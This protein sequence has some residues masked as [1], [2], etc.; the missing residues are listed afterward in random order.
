MKRRKTISR[1][2]LDELKEE[3]SCHR[4]NEWAELFH[5]LLVVAIICLV[6]VALWFPNILSQSFPEFAV[7]LGPVK[8]LVAGFVEIFVLVLELIDSSEKTR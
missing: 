1:M 8:A 7:I 4:N 2:N 6:V 3:L 5:I